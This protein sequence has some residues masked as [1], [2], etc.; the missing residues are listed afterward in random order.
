[1]YA[2]KVLL[3]FFAL[4]IGLGLVREADAAAAE[5]LRLGVNDNLSE[6]EA[7]PV[8]G[9]F[10]VPLRD[11]AKELELV[12]TVMTDEIE[13][14]GPNGILKLPIGKGTGISPDGS[15]FTL[16]TFVQN[17]KLMVPVKIVTCF[18]YT[19]SFNSEGYLLRVQD[20]SA[21][22]DDAAFASRFKD[23]LK[24][25]A[26]P[27]K[28]TF[29]MLGPHIRSYP[30]QGKRIAKEEHS[31]GL[32]GM[33]H[34]KD[35]F[36]ASPSA[37]L[38]EM[39]GD[40]AVLKKVAQVTTTLIRTPYG[41]KPYFSK[42][43]RDKVLSEGYNLWDWNVD[44]EDWKY[45]GDSSKIYNSVMVQIYKLQKTKFNPVILMHDQK[46]TLKVLPRILESLKKE[47][48]QFQFRSITDDMVAV[49]FWKDKR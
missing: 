12:L 17:G 9:T 15:E 41:S 49:N 11:L 28:T 32:H 29:F 33:T 19:I 38:A 27:V 37:A 20:A 10:Y 8:K 25:K 30:D 13:V 23:D 43:F 24:R 46:A 45:K 2:R 21:K 5:S 7:V 22:L 34:R 14:K 47:G 48:Y 26:D 16:D 44:S 42:P 40:N 4:I 31:L 3:L 36:Y 35:K 18:G 1:M 39:E 6:I